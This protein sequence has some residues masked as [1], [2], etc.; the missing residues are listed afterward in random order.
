MLTEVNNYWLD[1]ELK[2]FDYSENLPQTALLFKDKVQETLTISL[3]KSKWKLEEFLSLIIACNMAEDFCTTYNMQPSVDINQRAF[4][5]YHTYPLTHWNVCE[6]KQRLNQYY[7]HALALL[8]QVQKNR[9]IP[10]EVSPIEWL[11]LVESIG[12]KL[13]ISSAE[14]YLYE[15]IW[16]AS[17]KPGIYLTPKTVERIESSKKSPIVTTMAE[18]IRFH[19]YGI[20]ILIAKRGIFP[21][22]RLNVSEA[23]KYLG[24]SVNQLIEKCFEEENLGVYLKEGQFE[25]RKFL[26]T[27]SQCLTRSYIDEISKPSYL[28]RYKGLIRLEK[29]SKLYPDKTLEKIY[30]G[31]C[32][33][34]PRGDSYTIVPL[35]SSLAQLIQGIS[36][37]VELRKGEKITINELIFVRNE[38]YEHKHMPEEIDDAPLALRKF[39]TEQMKLSKILKPKQLW[40]Y[41]QKRIDSNIDRCEVITDMSDWADLD[42]KL[43]YK[44]SEHTDEKPISK[45]RFQNLVGEIQK[46]PS[47]KEE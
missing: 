10:I 5:E 28:C 20:D 15:V 11:E 21:V 26:T 23:A 45:K 31:S 36:Q 7:I 3:L 12:E 44:T 24:T 19:H 30:E 6:I 4:G 43:F 25:V 13:F 16:P 34:V 42:A 47:F 38:L 14:K 9:H 39:I 33:E 35:Q 8:K 46:T 22:S 37:V 1:E 41:L 40:V 32:I 17:P 27:N 2:Q 29:N 18:S